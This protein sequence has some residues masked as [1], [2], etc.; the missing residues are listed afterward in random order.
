MFIGT[1][2]GIFPWSYKQKYDVTSLVKSHPEVAYKHSSISYQ[3][4]SSWS[5][6]FHQVRISLS[7]CCEQHT[8]SEHRAALSST[9]GRCLT[10]SANAA[11]AS[12]ATF[13]CEVASFTPYLCL[14]HFSLTFTR[15]LHFT[16]EHEKST[17][18][19]NFPFQIHGRANQKR[20]PN[21]ENNI[22][23]KELPVLILVEYC[24]MLLLKSKH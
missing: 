14:R 21:R 24:L 19:L 3:C 13:D 1:I 15:K 11:V 16:L 18:T 23:T 5:Q 20:A 12:I 6:L 7:S 22:Y 8:H 9:G 10:W 4:R 17:Y 2:L